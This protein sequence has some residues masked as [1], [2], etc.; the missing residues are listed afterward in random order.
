MLPPSPPVE[1]WKAGK[2]KSLLLAEP[3][4]ETDAEYTLFMDSEA[5]VME[6][7]TN[8]ELTHNLENLRNKKYTWHS[9]RSEPKPKQTS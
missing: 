3:V 4:T 2:R 6:R 5:E 8:I 1:K 7:E 9:Y